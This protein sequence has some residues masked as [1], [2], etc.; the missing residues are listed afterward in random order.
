MTKIFPSWVLTCFMVNY[1][2]VSFTNNQCLDN[3]SAWT[4][5][6][7]GWG[8][9]WGAHF[10]RFGSKASPASLPTLPVSEPVLRHFTHCATGKWSARSAKFCRSHHFFRGRPF[11]QFFIST[12]P[13]R[14]RPKMPRIARSARARSHEFFGAKLFLKNIFLNANFFP[15]NF[16]VTDFFHPKYFSQNFTFCTKN[17]QWIFFTFS[18]IFRLR[19]TCAV[20]NVPS[21]QERGERAGERDRAPAGEAGRRGKFCIQI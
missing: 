21:E 3:H 16:G 4:T 7:G 18:K 2:H 14:S 20:V 6:W 19:R 1:L 12:P 13:R 5:W 9:Y 11:L 15:K 10:P 17:F 8:F